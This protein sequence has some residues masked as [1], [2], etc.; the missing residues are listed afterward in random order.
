MYENG[1]PSVSRVFDLE[2]SP[3]EEGS[4]GED[5]MSFIVEDGT[6]KKGAT[7]YATVAFFKAYFADRAVDISTLSDSAIQALL[8]AATDFID[9]RWGPHFLGS[10]YWDRYLNS[11]SILSLTGQPSD[12]NT[13]SVDG[14]TY[15]F[16]TTPVLA[17][18]TQIGATLADT[19]LALSSVGLSVFLPDPD[20]A[21]IAV[22]V[23]H[24]GVATTSSIVAGGFDGSTSS[25]RSGR[26]QLLEFPR[27]DLYDRDGIEVSGIPIKLRE[28]T[29]EYANRAR[30]AA[31]APDP[32]VEPGVT[33]QSKSVAGISVSTT[34]SNVRITKSYPAADRLL[35]EYVQLGGVVRS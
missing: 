31:L 2:A 24:D 8:I 23:D 10:R 25:G 14:T 18:E 7:S 27:S 21:S 5:L 34:W 3:S 30:T 17:T 20:V 26:G 29:C 12:G 9:T 33:S 35:A 19:L 15:T 13:I 32:T 4:T 16:R 1:Q 11:R 28:A 22:F 6:G